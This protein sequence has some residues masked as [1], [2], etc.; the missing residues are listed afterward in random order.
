MRLLR[1]NPRRKEKPKYAIRSEFAGG[2]CAGVVGG[3]AGA[4]RQRTLACRAEASGVKSIRFHLREIFLPA[5]CSYY[6][7]DLQASGL[8]YIAQDCG[9]HREFY[10]YVGALRSY[11][12][13]H[14]YARYYF[15][16]EFRC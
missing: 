16:T 10:R 14:I 1:I 13:I 3:I 11:V 7:W 8:R 6:D 15:E 12:S 9:R 4:I 2:Q 5:R